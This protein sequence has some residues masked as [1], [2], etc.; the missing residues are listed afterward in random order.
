MS[1]GIIN[2]SLLGGFDSTNPP[3][4]EIVS[5]KPKL[6]FDESTKEIVYKSFYLPDNFTVA[7][8]LKIQ[9]AMSDLGSPV[10]S[11]PGN[12]VW[13]CEVMAIKR[14]TA[15]VDTDSYDTAN[16]VVS[17]VPTQTDY[18]E[19]ASISLVNFDSATPGD[20]VTLKIYDSATS[21]DYVSLRIYRDAANG[22]DTA[23]GDAAIVSLSF[24]YALEPGNYLE[25]FTEE[26]SVTNWNFETG[27]AT[28]WTTLTGTPNIM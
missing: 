3:E 18:L 10:A 27:D 14:V 6:L 24:L 21:G 25:I 26:I 17:E 23:I 16:T 11:P 7:P 1:S 13:G 5:E 28:G 15:S 2:L 12:V 19:T 4:V 9:Y 22:S 8:V 20:W